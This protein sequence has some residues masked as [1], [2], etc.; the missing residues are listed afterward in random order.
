MSRAF[1]VILTIIAGLVLVIFTGYSNR[2][3]VLIN[4]HFLTMDAENSVVTSLGLQSGYIRARGDQADVIG[5][6]SRL[7]LASSWHERVFGIRYVDLG[8]QSVVPGFVDAHGHFPSNGLTGIGIDLSS[9]P[10][11]R[12]ENMS[13][14]MK[15]VAEQAQAQSRSRWIVGFNYDDAA[16]LEERHPTQ[17]ELDETA[18]DHAVFIRHRSGHMGV[19][20]SRAL[21]DLDVPHELGPGDEQP[22]HTNGLLKEKA[23][24]G[25]RRLLRE[26]PWW[27]FPAILFRARDDYLQA[28]VTT[29]QNG[30]ADKPTLQVLRYAVRFGLIPQRIVVWPAHDK[31]PVAPAI[32][33]AQVDK[34]SAS[35]TS[36]Q[37]L[38][39][40]IDWPMDD[41]DRVAIGA[42]KLVADGS[43]QGRTAWLSKPY[44]HDDQLG[45]GY[46][47]LAYLQEKTLRTLIVNYHKAGFQLAVHGNGDAAIQSIIDALQAAYQEFPRDD[48]RHFVVHAQT[49]RPSQLQQLADLDVS[50]SFFPSHTFYWGDW[51]RRRV[52]GESRA[53]LISPLASADALGVRYT[54]HADS[55]V[56]PVNP[57]QMIWSATERL[58]SSGYVL[59]ADERVSRQRALRALTIDAAWQN[60][61][62][63]DRGSI[64]V[65][66][67]A[68][69]VVM[70]ANPLTQEDVRDIIVRQVW[71]GGKRHL[72]T[73]P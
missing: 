48:A 37:R 29:V 61:L 67:L 28:G 18:P 35:E 73:T 26:I 22:G 11:G 17:A 30:F 55:P 72:H 71:I 8:G 68:D 7:N 31:L 45:D 15:K 6:M 24:P 59:G 10:F 50:V 25:M 69:F 32:S 42:I 3:I 57:L 70:S 9:P 66:K 54:L 1:I 20:N 14:L 46:R 16:L 43:P 23:A 13:M 58:T 33:Y 39:V 47:G 27:K 62:E 56:T 2:P 49:I 40:A 41:R 36:G 12:I 64:E 53:A 21:M 44:L 4:G 51:Y 65:G 5:E 52:L 19:A 63:N 38:A 34:S 60:H